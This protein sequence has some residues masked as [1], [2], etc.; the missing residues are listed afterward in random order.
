MVFEFAIVVFTLLR[1]MAGAMC[2]QAVRRLSAVPR[3]IHPVCPF[4]V[5]CA[6]L[7]SETRVTIAQIALRYLL[8]HC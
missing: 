6:V 8:W 5:L 1:A 2:H 3:C 4:K 7:S